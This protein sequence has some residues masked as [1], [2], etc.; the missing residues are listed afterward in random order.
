MGLGIILPGGEEFDA[1][2]GTVK[3]VQPTADQMRQYAWVER[4]LK[5][6]ASIWFKPGTEESPRPCMYY[7]IIGGHKRFLR[8]WLPYYN[9]ND[10][11]DDVIFEWGWSIYK[12]SVLVWRD[13]A[14]SALEGKPG[15]HPLPM[16][17][18]ATE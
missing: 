4:S 10:I 13:S 12:T 1:N 6:T 15:D 7:E 16:W 11:S 2:G 5:H 9:P 8:M 18:T 3:P 14:C 17:H